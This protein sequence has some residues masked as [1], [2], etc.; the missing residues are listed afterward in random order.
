MPITAI[1]LG[2]PTHQRG[3]A[4]QAV[5]LR[6]RALPSSF[7]APALYLQLRIFSISLGSRSGWGRPL[8]RPPPLLPPPLLRL[9]L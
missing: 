9:L 5:A 6:R 3:G 4:G 2:G 7:P 1:L 8:L